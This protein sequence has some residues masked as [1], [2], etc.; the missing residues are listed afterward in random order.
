MIPFGE[1]LCKLRNKRK[2]SQA[3]LARKLGLSASVIG[4]YETGERYPS[5]QVLIDISRFFGVSIDYM[6]GLSDVQ[7]E[8]VDVLGLSV[9]QIATITA[10][11]EQY[12][13]KNATES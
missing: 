11:I 8:F 6:L 12:R 2:L 4:Y 3:Q 9:D 5:L 7:T 1:K 13:K 10:I